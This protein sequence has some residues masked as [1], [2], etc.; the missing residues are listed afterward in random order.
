MDQITIKSE[1]GTLVWTPPKDL[2]DKLSRAPEWVRDAAQQWMVRMIEGYMCALLDC[3]RSGV[4]VEWLS[5]RTTALVTDAAMLDLNP[6]QTPAP[7]A[8]KMH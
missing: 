6:P 1:I 2:Q 3:Q 5:K 4:G 8:D 7:P